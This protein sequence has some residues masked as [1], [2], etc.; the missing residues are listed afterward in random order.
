MFKTVQKEVWAYDAEWVP[1][2]NAG[3]VLYEVPEDRTGAVVVEHMWHWN[4]ASE[5]R[6]P[7][8]RRNCAIDSREGSA[9]VGR[10]SNSIWFRGN[11]LP[12]P[13]HDMSWLS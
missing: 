9:L 2:A 3:R 5:E 10:A 11:L 7:F 6:K 13:D 4:S 12:P 1:H 8:V